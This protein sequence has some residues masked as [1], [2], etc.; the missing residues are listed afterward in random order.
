MLRTTAEA[1]G[2]G[3]DPGKHVKDPSNLLLTVPERYFYVVPQCYMS[4]CIWSPAI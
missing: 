2:E 4:M 3:L 1:K